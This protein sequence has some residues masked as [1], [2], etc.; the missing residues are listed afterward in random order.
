VFRGKSAADYAD[1]IAAIRVAAGAGR[2]Q[3]LPDGSGTP[4]RLRATALIR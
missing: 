1:N 3:N 2:V 4:T